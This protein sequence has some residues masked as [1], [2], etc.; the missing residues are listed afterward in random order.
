MSLKR[1]HLFSILNSFFFFF[2]L[3]KNID[4]KMAADTPIDITGKQVFAVT[5]AFV[6][7]NNRDFSDGLV[8]NSSSYSARVF[9]TLEAAQ[10]YMKERAKD[11]YYANI[12]DIDPPEGEEEDEEGT[13]APE[14]EYGG[15]FEV[16]PYEIRFGYDGP[17]DGIHEEWRGLEKI[18]KVR[19]DAW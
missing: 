9:S 19:V 13:P 1:L 8:L 15:F 3:I 17:N 16:S 7:P 11:I 10:T 2:S 4:K 12:D 14:G 5:E 18:E 6:G